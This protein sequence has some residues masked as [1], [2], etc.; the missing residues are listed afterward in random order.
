MFDTPRAPSIAEDKRNARFI[1][2]YGSAGERH[3][4]QILAWT[5]ISGIVAVG[6]LI[7][8]A[9][10]AGDV[11][12]SLRLYDEGAAMERP[13]NATK[14]PATS[15]QLASEDDERKAIGLPHKLT[16]QMMSSTEGPE[17]CPE[18]LEE[19][20]AVMRGRLQVP[21]AAS[22][23]PPD[24]TK[25]HFDQIMT[26][27]ADGP[28][29]RCLAQVRAFAA[30][31]TDAASSESASSSEPA[32]GRE[33]YDVGCRELDQTKLF[34]KRY[35]RGSAYRIHCF[36]PNTDFRA[37]H[38]AFAAANPSLRIHFY[39]AAAGAANGTAVLS[40]R[41]V[42]GSVVR[43][44]PGDRNGPA[45]A[46]HVEVLDFAAL[47]AAQL[48]DAALARHPSH[49]VIKMDAE[50]MEFAVLHRMLDTLSIAL[51]DDLLLECHYNTNLSPALRDPAK[52]IGLDDCRQMVAAL[53]EALGGNERGRPFE[54][55]LWNNA[56]TAKASGYIRRHNG[57]H[58]S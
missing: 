49:V 58:P 47:I 54:A 2:T 8:Q 42:G 23:M 52:H 48:S 45:G 26:M 17:S 28:R 57:F 36:E 38:A 13:S 29:R 3:R 22:A 30:D 33:F 39:D 9:S 24:S 56:K 6:L 41:S 55:V 44:A 21:R 4:R 27:L 1:R 43:E 50:K 32:G 15:G 46:R 18:S 35:P 25:W 53:G 11:L 34:V 14:S 12:S 19:A 31:R 40:D 16:Q 51:V 10:L 37:A 7:M 20:I 5:A